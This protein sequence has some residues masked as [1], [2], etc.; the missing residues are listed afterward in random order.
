M[1]GPWAR[2]IGFGSRGYWICEKL[3]TAFPTPEP[4][5][6]FEEK[7]LRSLGPRRESQ[8]QVPPADDPFL[9]AKTFLC[10]EVGEWLQGTS[11]V[12]A[13]SPNAVTHTCGGV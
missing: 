4:G 11:W 12:Q 6:G 7:G 5:H 2:L 8:S 10:L 13:C 3:Q 9:M 1:T